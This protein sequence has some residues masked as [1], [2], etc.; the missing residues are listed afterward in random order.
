MTKLSNLSKTTRLSLMCIIGVL[1]IVTIIYATR[2]ILH[3]S[4]LAVVLMPV[5]CGILLRCLEVIDRNMKSI[6]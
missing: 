3:G 2:A 6:S 4:L 1:L 5:I